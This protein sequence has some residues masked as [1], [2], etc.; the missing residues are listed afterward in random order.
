LLK[1]KKKTR[2]PPDLGIGELS[3]FEQNGLNDLIEPLAG[4]IAKGKEFEE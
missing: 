4:Q 1:K 3:E 2:V